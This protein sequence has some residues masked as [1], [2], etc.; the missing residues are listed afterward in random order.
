DQRGHQHGDEHVLVQHGQQGRTVECLAVGGVEVLAER[1]DQHGGDQHE[2]DRRLGKQP[3]P[4][5]P[6]RARL[7]GEP[8]GGGHCS[9][10]AAPSSLRSSRKVWMVS[11]TVSR[12][13]VPAYWPCGSVTGTAPPSASIASRASCNVDCVL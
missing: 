10:C 4:F 6:P 1:P 2:H 12:W 11:M 3:D 5:R 7:G 13:I 8:E 9:S